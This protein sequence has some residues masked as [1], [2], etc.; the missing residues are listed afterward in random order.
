[1]YNGSP[2][3]TSTL[4]NKIFFSSN[5]H[6][7]KKNINLINSVVMFQLFKLLLNT[8][9]KVEGLNALLIIHV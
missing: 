1:M 3:F 4:L 2:F 7:N 6:R 5:H 8:K 9:A